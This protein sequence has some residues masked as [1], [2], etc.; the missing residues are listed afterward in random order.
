MNH[1]DTS[2]NSDD[3][4]RHDDDDDDVD[5][6]DL[7]TIQDYQLI[8][9]EIPCN[10]SNRNN[11]DDD[12]DTAVN[13]E[14]I[15]TTTT[16]HHP[17]HHDDNDDTTATAEATTT[18]SAITQRL[19]SLEIF[20]S[21]AACTD[22]DLTGQVLWPVSRLLSHYLAA[23]TQSQ[24]QQQH[25]SSPSRQK[26]Q[27]Q[28]KS[29]LELGAG[30]T[31]LPSL[32]AAWCGAA[33]VVATDGNDGVVLDL[34]RR[35][36]EHYCHQQQEQQQPPHHP[37][38]NA[39]GQR[40]GTTTLPNLSCRQLLWGHRDHVQKLRQ[41]VLEH[42]H[43]TN[44]NHGHRHHHHH[45]PSRRPTFD[46]IVAAD[47]VQWPAV[48]EPLL[49]TAHAFMWHNDNHSSSAADDDNDDDD[50]ATESRFILGIVE[51]SSTIY[52]QFF[53][54][55][56]TMG[57]RY[58]HIDYHEYLQNGIVPISCQEYGGRVTKLFELTLLPRAYSETPLLLR[59]TE[60]LQQSENDNGDNVKDMNY[61]V[62]KL[63]Q[64]T[65]FLPC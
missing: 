43:E 42:Y 14:S 23:V 17:L 35:N 40:S 61:T 33:L 5:L 32:V 56:T 46:Y 59:S 37:H 58:R 9:V 30:G 1:H 20:Q 27:L 62:G 3:R 19:L 6:Y 21:P 34:L 39:L 7:F 55:A 48:L 38:H 54:L 36:I 11:D 53:S 50:E 57:F 10:T 13:V 64:H 49:H 4:E 51:R 28:N 60:E 25:S 65:T 2:N 47:V 52:E 8:T 45:H 63:Y 22:P 16:H 29:V 44:T 41:E 31:G 18:T 26:S 12:D 24:P 15:T